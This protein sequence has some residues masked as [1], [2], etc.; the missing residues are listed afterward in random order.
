MSWA[1]SLFSGSFSLPM[2]N[3]TRPEVLR[4][5]EAAYAWVTPTRL[6]PSTW[7][8]TLGHNVEME[9]WDS[10]NIWRPAVTACCSAAVLQWALVSPVHGHG[11]RSVITLMTNDALGPQL[12]SLLCSINLHCL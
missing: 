10:I 6:A 2:M 1:T 7:Q 9:R 4:S 5:T 12:I 8:Q 11:W 3:W